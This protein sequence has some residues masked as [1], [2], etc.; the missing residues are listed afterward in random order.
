MTAYDS[1]I[2]VTYLHSPVDHPFKILHSQAKEDIKASVTFDL[3][4]KTGLFRSDGQRPE[5]EPSMGK[6]GQCP[7]RKY[8]GAAR[9][10]QV[11]Y[12]L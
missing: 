5:G 2:S 8:K 4:Y 6:D 10:P 11:R 3:L 9:C 1:C 12:A 7:V